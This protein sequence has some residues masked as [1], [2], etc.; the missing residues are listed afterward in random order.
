M[1]LD[2]F[3]PTNAMSIRGTAAKGMEEMGEL[4]LGVILAEKVNLI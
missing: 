2:I 4:F 1:V 3:D